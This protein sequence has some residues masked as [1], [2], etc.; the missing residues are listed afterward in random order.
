[1][2]PF[3]KKATQKGGGNFSKSFKL[4]FSSGIS[5]YLYVYPDN[6]IEFVWAPL[7]PYTPER[8]KEIDSKFIPWVKKCLG[9]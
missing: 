8:V 3:N 1:M 2:W 5:V 4:D 9:Q 7:P 6:H